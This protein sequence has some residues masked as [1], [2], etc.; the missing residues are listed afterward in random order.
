M[1]S[2]INFFEEVQANPGI[3]RGYT[4]V[5]FAVALPFSSFSASPWYGYYGFIKRDLG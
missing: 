3:I 4:Q 2:H 5:F 1:E